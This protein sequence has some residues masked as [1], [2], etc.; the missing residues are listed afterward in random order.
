MSEFVIK[1]AA[2]SP[3]LALANPLKNAERQAAAAEKAA[4][5]G[6]NFIVFPAMSLCG[7]TC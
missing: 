4:A 6:C 5:E 1:A 3:R 2:L 7:A